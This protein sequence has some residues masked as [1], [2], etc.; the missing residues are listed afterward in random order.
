MNEATNPLSD[1]PFWLAVSGGEV[2]VAAALLDDDPSLV[3]RDFRKIEEQD[4]HT[5]GFPLV[6]ASETGNLEMVSLLLDRGADIDAKSH[7]E[8]QRE[9]GAPIMLAFE[10]RRYDLIHYLLDRGASVAA[11][12]WCYPSLVD[13][14]YEDALAF[15]NAHEIAR[16]GFVEYLGESDVPEVQSD[17][18]AEALKLFVR[19]IDMGGQPSVK[20][21]VELRNYETAELLLR[22]CPEK[23]STIHDYPKGSVFESLCWSAAW[24]GIPR[25][26]TMAMELC[27]HLYTVKMSLDVLNSAVKSHN[28]EGL[29]SEY[30]ELIETQLKFLQKLKELE[31]VIDGNHFL[32]HFQLAANYLW[33][34]WCGN[35]K[36]PSTVESMIELSRLF[37]RYGFDNVNSVDS[38]SNETALARARSRSEHPG[39]SDFADYLASVGGK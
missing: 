37:F 4:P 22:T 25:A 15:G 35:E 17:D 9:L 36:D 18:A 26:L 27:P 7:C 10:Q 38:E 21:I 6:K 3:D 33:P 11:Y 8:E 34:G 12:G 32:P 31:S 20:A 30:F 29:A 28:R 23:A 2:S 14:S 5:N 19:L 39:L 1:H 13:L 16:Q 24:H